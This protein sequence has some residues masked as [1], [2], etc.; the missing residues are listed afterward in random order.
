MLHSDIISAFGTKLTRLRT[1]LTCLGQQHKLGI[2]YS[3]MA[4]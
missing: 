2:N 4:C 3:Q 1:K